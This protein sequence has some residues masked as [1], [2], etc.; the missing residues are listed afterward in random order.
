MNWA[1]EVVQKNS[2]HF[3]VGKKRTTGKKLILLK[4]F[5]L[6]FSKNC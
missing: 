6:N 1:T 5:F 4:K 3:F 2:L